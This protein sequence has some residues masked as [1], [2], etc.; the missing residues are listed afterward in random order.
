MGVLI[1]EDVW[2][3]GVAERARAAADE[4]LA[5][6]NGSPFDI[7]HLAAREAEF[8]RRLMSAGVARPA[9]EVALAIRRS[10]HYAAQADKFDGAVHS[11]KSAH[12]TLAMPEPFGVI[13]LA[14]PNDAPHARPFLFQF[15]K[16]EEFPCPPSNA[17]PSRWPCFP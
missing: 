5:V 10:F 13:G 11:T 15:Q 7:G 1:C 12:V 8:A 14:C 16:P 2:H 17:Q 4:V 6:I 9:E 3:P